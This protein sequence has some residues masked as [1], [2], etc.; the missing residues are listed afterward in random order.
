MPNDG[1]IFQAAMS[2]D[3]MLNIMEIGI[4]EYLRKPGY[5]DC[6]NFRRADIVEQCRRLLALLTTDNDHGE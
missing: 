2:I 5:I 3:D 6:V 1:D 4:P